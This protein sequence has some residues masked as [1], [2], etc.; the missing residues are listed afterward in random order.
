M[1]RRVKFLNS[2][3]RILELI[4]GHLRIVRQMIDQLMNTSDCIKNMNW[5]ELDRIWGILDVLESEAD[6]V[7]ESIVTT[8]CEGSYFGGIFSEL[9]LLTE[10]IDDIADSAKDAVRTLTQREPDKEIVKCLRTNDFDQFLRKCRDTVYALDEAVRG[11]GV[12]RRTALERTNGIKKHE[13]DADLYKSRLLKTLFS[14]CRST[15]TLGVL[16]LQNFI[17]T[18]DQIADNAED[19][20]DLIRVL[21][22]RGYG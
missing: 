15:D 1:F 11:L 20:G 3:D 10:K 16:Q 7:H 21:I 22:T 8:I 4:E 13:E 12:N 18:V 5:N 9:L 17:N 2:G 6:H 14:E 19:A